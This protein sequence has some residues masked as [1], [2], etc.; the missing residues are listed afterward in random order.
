MAA[1][2][3]ERTPPEGDHDER[4]TGLDRERL[5][6][7]P[8][9]VGL[10][11]ER[12]AELDAW[13]AELDEREGY[14]I[15]PSA[16][17]ATDARIVAERLE[18]G[19][20]TVIASGCAIR[21]EVRIGAFCSLNMGATTIGRVTLGDWVRVATQVVLVG[22]NHI[23]DD[24]DKPIAVQGLRTE[25]IVVEDDVWIGAHV[26]VLDGVTVG[27]HSVLAAGAVVSRDVPPWSVVAGVPAR[28]I[29]RRAQPAAPA[30]EGDP[31]SSR[32]GA[33]SALP[34]PL[35]RF[36]ALVCDQWPAVLER[37]RVPV[38]RL[39]EGGEHVPVVAGLG[40]YLDVPGGDWHPRPLNDAVEI[41]AAFGGHL[42]AERGALI[43]AIQGQQDPTTGMF[44][45]P[46]TEPAARPL[47]PTHDEWRMYGILSCGYALEA[48]GSAPAHPVRAVEDCDASATTS[49]LDGLDWGVLA[50]PSGSWVDAFGTAAALNQRHH[51]STRR[52]EALW[53]WLE[54][55]NRGDSGMW[56]HH[57][58]DVD[59]QFGWLMAVNGY[60][61]MTRGTYAQFGRP[62]PRPERAIDTVL[63]HA[64][65][66]DW[67]AAHERT[68][69][70][71][72]DIVHPLWL[73]GQQTPYRRTEI[74]DG[75]AGLLTSSVGDWIDGAGFAFHTG[76]GPPGLQGTEMWLSIIYL[77]ADLLGTS[78]GL[79]WRP[80]GVHR[81]EPI[82]R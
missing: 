73:L 21:G 15:H 38:D 19:V 76:H 45:L 1:M 26:T 65:A 53:G 4:W 12:P 64:R 50:W 31:S 59:A 49:L 68:A 60:Y 47:H 36:D 77:A 55:N 9:L 11:G 14:R 28:V 6:A 20:G 24:P 13:I 8:W 54:A 27:A 40:T 82:A 62:L 69:C 66:T 35:A 16:V 67:F 48:L 51:G 7:E 58:P 63:A 42:P 71:V 81:L 46:G 52:H 3:D 61:R 34:E 74:R 37:C 25:G 80:R 57:L 43:D 29:R 39:P 56:G 30:A 17:V 2:D 22:E 72:L 5:G 23:F 32:T 70:N 75:I 33:G 41:A 18:V 10:L 44:V 79:G 78:D